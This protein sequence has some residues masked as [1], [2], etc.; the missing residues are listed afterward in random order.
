MSVTETGAELPFCAVVIPQIPGGVDFRSAIVQHE[1][2]GG[3]EQI[4][5]IDAGDE[6]AFK[7]RRLS[8]F[9]SVD[10]DDGASFGELGVRE[11]DESMRPK[12]RS[13]FDSLKPGIQQE[14]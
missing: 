3:F 10:A 8:M 2:A 4:L 6:F 13:M 14:R 1:F 7:Q 9:E 12:W 11:T 5:G